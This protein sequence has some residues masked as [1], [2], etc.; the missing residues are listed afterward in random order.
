MSLRKQV[1][2]S[3]DA[4]GNQSAVYL[5]FDEKGA[6]SRQ[7]NRDLKEGE[8][9][10]LFQMF[11]GSQGEEG[12]GQELARSATAGQTSGEVQESKIA[13][14]AIDAQKG[15][16][17]AGV[18][19]EGGSGIGG[20][21]LDKGSEGSLFSGDPNVSDAARKREDGAAEPRMEAVDLNQSAQPIARAQRGTRVEESQEGQ[22]E[23]PENPVE[24]DLQ[25]KVAAGERQDQGGTKVLPQNEGLGGVEPP[26]KAGEEPEGGNEGEEEDLNALHVPELK[27]RAKEAGVTG[28]SKMGK[29]ELIEAI[30]EAEAEE[31]QDDGTPQERGEAKLDDPRSAPPPRASES[32]KALK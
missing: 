21:G 17:V 24:D 11:G 9:Q 22:V 19:G 7:E 20:G 30:Q 6:L 4:D 10:D 1:R 12:E 23:T 29:E 14:A 8:K 32:D 5:E 27:D 16:R 25:G 15:S 28:Y 13:V 18:E 2:I 3:E 26:R 31:E